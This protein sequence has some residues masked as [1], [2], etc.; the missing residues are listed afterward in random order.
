MTRKEESIMAQ[1]VEQCVYIFAH[2]LF[3]RNQRVASLNRK[4]P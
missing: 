2:V 3:C 1:M 4:A